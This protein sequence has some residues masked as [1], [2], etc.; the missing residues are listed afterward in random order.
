MPD[1]LDLFAKLNVPRTADMPRIVDVW[2]GDVP[3][4]SDDMR[5]RQHVPRSSDLQYDR[6][7]LGR[8]LLPRR[9][10]LPRHEYL[11]DSNLRRCGHL[12]W[13]LHLRSS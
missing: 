10:D 1:Q 7:V 5:W 3:R 4:N 13:V 8:E 2:S 9:C 12:W 11:P 6:D